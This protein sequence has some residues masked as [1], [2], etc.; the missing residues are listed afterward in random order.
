M[1]PSD[2]VNMTAAEIDNL[3]VE[4]E[5]ALKIAQENA[6][7]VKLEKLE[8]DRQI[9][10]LEGKKKDLQV[11]LSKAQHIVGTIKIDI[12]ILTSAF[13]RAKNGGL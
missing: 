7:K 2:F 11:A 1:K 12:D 9:I 4:K 13:F 5:K 3:K 6:Y 8:I 10:A